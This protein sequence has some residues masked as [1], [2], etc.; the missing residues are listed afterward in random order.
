M[1]TVTAADCAGRTRLLILQSTPFCNIDCDYCYLP[2]RSDRH[3]MP[4]EIVEAAVAFVFR[5]ALPALDFTIVWHAGEP[6]VL[7]VDWY[8]QAF[9]TVRRAAPEAA[10]IPHSVQTNAMLV[11]DEWC[12]FFRENDVRVGVSLDGP[13]RIH[14]LRRVTR[15]GKGTHAR[16]MKGIETLRR[17]GVPFHVICVVGADTLAAADELVDFFLSEDIRDVGFNIEEIEGVHRRSS[18]EQQGADAKFRMF[19]GRLLERAGTADPP[20]LVREQRELLE[21]LR[22]PQFGRLARN[23]QNEPFGLLSVSSRGGLYTF[24]P[25]LA[26]LTDPRYGDMAVGQ[27]PGADLPSILSSPAFLRMW[28]DIEAGTESC[29]RSCPYFDLCLGGAPA[30][31]L[32]ECGTFAARETMH[33]RLSHQAIADAVLL[34][35]EAKLRGDAGQPGCATASGSRSAPLRPAP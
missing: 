14:D 34:E 27:L 15:S 13:A 7:P 35:L 16:V 6:L 31:K 22:H 10:H 12:A 23:S 9:A 20:L 19:F 8:R 17:N 2:A 33:C 24:S 29:K 26:G 32:A 5:H 21:A 11:T 18:L 4:L 30:N 28:F 1:T 3:R 25:E